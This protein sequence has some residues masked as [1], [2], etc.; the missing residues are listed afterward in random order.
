MTAPTILQVLPALETG[1]VERG[2]VQIAAATVKAGWRAIVASAGGGMVRELERTGARHIVL[3]LDT[4]NPFVI[5]S[6]IDRISRLIQAEGVDLVHA[7]S[8][9]PAWSAWIAAKRLNI[10]FVTTFHATY[11][12]GSALK[13][14]YN[15]VMVR[16]EPIIAIS[17]HIARHIVETYK[18]PRERLRV[19]P[20]GIDFERFAPERMQP[21]RMLQLAKDWRLPDDVAVV[22]L[23]GRL[24]RWKGQS[25]LIEALTHLKRTDI[26]CILAGS[27]QGR[28]QY[29]QELERL[30]IGQ[31]LSGRVRLVGDCQDMPA[32]YMLADVVVSA[33]T[34]PEGFG[35]VSIEAQAMGRPIIATDHGGSRET[36]LPGITGWLVPPGD[37]LALA[38]A[39]NDAVDLSTEARLR[40]AETAIQHAREH[41]DQQMMC[42]STLAVYHE[43]LTRT[44][45]QQSA[46]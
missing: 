33:S 11:G 41:F 39:L 2:A 8:R 10:P 14:L 46:A 13:R 32:A 27:D 34:D 36:I 23:P 17:E 45:E 12:A 40:L 24:S 21:H 28:T 19:I 25:V 43:A 35:R 6:N 5:R 31:G 15:A 26:I 9:A 44:A 20:R 16:G 37:S 7:R 3:P 38:T 18:V 42:D 4:K 22:L 29:R 1:G 30:V